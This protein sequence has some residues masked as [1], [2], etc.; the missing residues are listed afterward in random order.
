MGADVVVEGGPQHRGHEEDD[1][2]LGHRLDDLHDPLHHRVH[3]P[4]AVAGDGAVEG[5]DAQHQQGGADAHQH[6]DPGAHHDP[7]HDV[8][9]EAVGAENVGE[10]ILPG[11]LPL[12][13][14]AGIAEGLVLDAQLLDHR[15]PVPGGLGLG[16][17]LGDLDGGEGPALGLGFRLGLLH[18][19]LRGDHGRLDGQLVLQGVVPGVEVLRPGVELIVAVGHHHGAHEGKEHDAHQDHQ[20]HHGHGVL[21]HPPPGILPIGGGGAVLDEVLLLLVGRGGKVRA[22]KAAE[23][24]GLLIEMEGEGLSEGFLLCHI[25]HSPFQG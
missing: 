13:L 22:G 8:T 15:L 5:A 2:H 1:Q 17:D 21:A 12:Q 11:G 19:L 25:S 20:G 16:P 3:H 9:A 6:G 7:D 14:G 10:D 23:V 4:A 24:E 18:R